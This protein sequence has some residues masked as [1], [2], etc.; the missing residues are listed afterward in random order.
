MANYREYEAGFYDN[1]WQYVI[2]ELLDSGGI[3]LYSVQ[4]YRSG[5]EL[6]DAGPSDPLYQSPQEARA[7]IPSLIAAYP[8]PSHR[9]EEPADE[10]EGIEKH[11][12]E[13][14]RE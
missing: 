12:P 2:W 14:D 4:I 9:A 6:L 11:A 8:P 13:D 1:E 10:K 5:E 3:E 7:T